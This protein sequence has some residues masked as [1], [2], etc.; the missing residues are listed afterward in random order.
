MPSWR[1]RRPAHRASGHRPR[2]EEDAAH[3]PAAGEGRPRGGDGRH[4]AGAG[5]R[6]PGRA[7]R[8]LRQRAGRAARLARLRR[9]AVARRVCAPLRLD[10]A[11]GRLP[12]RRARAG[13]RGCPVPCPPDDRSD[14]RPA[15]WRRAARRGRPVAAHRDPDRRRDRGGLPTASIA[16]RTGSR[17]P[18]RPWRPRS[19]RAPASS[20]RRWSS[21]PRGANI[22]RVIVGLSD[23]RGARADP[24]DRGERL[25]A[26]RERPMPLCCCGRATILLDAGASP[27][28][29]PARARA[30]ADN[31]ELGQRE[32]LVVDRQPAHAHDP[33]GGADE[34][35]SRKAESSPAGWV[36]RTTLSCSARC[37]GESIGAIAPGAGEGSVRSRTGRSS[38]SRLS[39]TRP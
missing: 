11:D 30:L 13:R 17:S 24:V 33:P 36:H 34:A 20:A 5:G 1:F 27:R 37:G 38:S 6:E 9:D 14:T 22:L 32:R 25:R 21:R 26:V 3:G 16:W 18:T 31:P 8:A 10:A 29:D 2:P 15:G 28:P 23:R 39:P 7:A 12:A 19:R 35:S 4:G